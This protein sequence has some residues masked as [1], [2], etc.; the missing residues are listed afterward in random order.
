MPPFV[1]DNEKDSICDAA[2]RWAEFS[3]DS[4]DHPDIRDS[5]RQ[6]IEGTLT[7]IPIAGLHHEII[8]EPY[9]GPLARQLGAVLR[10]V[11]AVSSD[12][13]EAPPGALVQASGAKEPAKEMGKSPG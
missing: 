5:W 4:T 7:V 1:I 11:Q 6:V 8:Q 9:A 12:A 13:P 2:R 3:H 10:K